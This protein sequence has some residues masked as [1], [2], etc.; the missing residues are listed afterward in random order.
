MENMT[1]LEKLDA[2]VSQLLQK[3]DALSQENEMMRSELVTIKAEKEIK[4]AEI[5]RLVEENSRK[6]LEI[7]EIVAKI[8]TILG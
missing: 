5:E 4:D 7:E 1:A 3:C 6:D 2:K 8:E